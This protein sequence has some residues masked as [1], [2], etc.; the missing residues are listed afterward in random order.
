MVRRG[1]DGEA[2]RRAKRVTATLKAVRAMRPARN[3]I[4][5]CTGLR[6]RGGVQYWRWVAMG[7]GL[8]CKQK[9]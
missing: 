6:L 7:L 8:D 9:R 2:G 1:G 3:E 4:I 5:I